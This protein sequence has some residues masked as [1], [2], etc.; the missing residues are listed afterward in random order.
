VLGQDRGQQVS[1]LPDFEPTWCVVVV[2]EVGVST[3]QAFRDWDALCAAEGLTPEASADKLKESSHAY[4][5]AFSGSSE[6]VGKAG[7]SG[8]FSMGED[9]AGPQESKHG[10]GLVR[11]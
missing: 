2:P 4:A 7:S 5:A 3:P 9:L 10:S 1:P 8:V 6:W 11:T